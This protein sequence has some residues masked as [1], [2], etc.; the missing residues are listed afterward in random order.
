[1]QYCMDSFYNYEKNAH[2]D[3]YTLYTKCGAA[4]SHDSESVNHIEVMWMLLPGVV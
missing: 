4:T 3:R 1:M 2:V